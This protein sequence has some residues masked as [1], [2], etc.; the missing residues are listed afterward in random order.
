MEH[1]GGKAKDI[2]LGFDAKG[3]GGIVNAS[4]SLMCAYKLD[5]WKTQF[6]EEE[7]ALATRA[8]AIRMRDELNK[9]IK[10]L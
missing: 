1:Q 10:A 3:L 2:A 5:K 6:K 8:E 9:A 4:R 7:Y